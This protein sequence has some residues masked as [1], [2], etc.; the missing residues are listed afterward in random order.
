MRFS[1]F[2]QDSLIMYSK[3]LIKYYYQNFLLIL[4]FTIIPD[5]IQTT[6]LD[7]SYV[8]VTE[9]AY[10]L[11]SP[12]IPFDCRI[13]LSL[14]FKEKIPLVKK[15]GLNRNLLSNLSSA[16]NNESSSHARVYDTTERLE[17]GDLGCECVDHSL[18]WRRWP[19]RKH[20]RQYRP[21]NIETWGILSDLF[22][23]GGL[24]HALSRFF[25]LP[26]HF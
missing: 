24:L 26:E 20:C 23:V 15:K 11:N 3:I 12:R 19:M 9:R 16:W 22:S 10:L 6:L 25:A 2:L 7:N 4:L 5:F 18:S 17:Y 13:K 14:V 8:K 21:Y 1:F